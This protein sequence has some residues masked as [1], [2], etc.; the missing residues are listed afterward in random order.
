MNNYAYKRKVKEHFNHYTGIYL[1]II[2]FLILGIAV[3]SILSKVLDK[4]QVD[5]LVKFM[6]SYFKVLDDSQISSTVL[7]KHS[8]LTN[9]KTLGLLWLFGLIVIGAPLTFC[10]VAVRGFIM[11]FTV[12]FLLTEFGFKGLLFSLLA[13]LPQN[14]FVIPGLIILSVMSITYSTNFMKKKKT[15]YYNANKMKNIVNYSVGM[16]VISSLFLIGSVIEA[17]FSPMLMKIVI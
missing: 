7:L 4:A 5:S 2:I 16:L 8:I 9:L 12:S 14:I 3:G 13:I 6:D 17:Y 11:G 10:L 1:V 15:Y